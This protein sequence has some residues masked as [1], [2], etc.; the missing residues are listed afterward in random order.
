MAMIKGRI[1]KNRY[2]ISDK[3]TAALGER[4]E[5]F[6]RILSYYSTIYFVE[7]IYF[8]FMILII[9]GRIAAVISGLTFASLLVYHVIGLFFQ[10]NSSRKLQI[11]LMD[12]HVAFTAGF[13]IN[14]IFGDLPISVIDEFMIIYRGIAALMAI[15]LILIFTDD[16]II[17]EYS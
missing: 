3:I 8:M 6:P 12:I 10:K 7:I 11:I 14:R 13:L 2:M 4:K 17:K 9:Y 16:E 15:P 5:K 1:I